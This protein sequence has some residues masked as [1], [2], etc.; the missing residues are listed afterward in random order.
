[1]VY[2]ELIKFYL[3][4][5]IDIRFKKNLLDSPFKWTTA[6][7]FPNINLVESDNEVLPITLL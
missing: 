2:S 1:M 6:F 7:R 4:E 3:I 5:K